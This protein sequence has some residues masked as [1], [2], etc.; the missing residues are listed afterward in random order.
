MGTVLWDGVLFFA[1]TTPITLA[2]TLSR[3]CVILVIV[4]V[5]WVFWAHKVRFERGWMNGFE[6]S[7]FV[8]GFAGLIYVTVVRGRNGDPGTAFILLFVNMAEAIA[9]DFCGTRARSPNGIAGCVLLAR[10]WSETCAHRPTPASG[11]AEQVHSCDVSLEWIVGYTSWNAAF[12]FG[13]GFSWSTRF[14]LVTA[15]LVSHVVLRVPSAWLSARCYSMMLNMA[16]RAVQITSVYTPG[17]TFLTHADSAPRS[18]ATVPL[19][20]WGLINCV[21][22]L[23]MAARPTGMPSAGPGTLLNYQ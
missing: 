7:K 12:S 19:L 14:I 4:A 10:F 17:K 2:L 20:T 21:Y 8:A 23:G 5:A 15:F 22:V 3:E 16:L 13:H 11:L 6:V 9:Y 18:V 1:L